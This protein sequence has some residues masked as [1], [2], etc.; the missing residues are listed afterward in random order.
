MNEASKTNNLRG[1]D[2]S[3][4]YLK[5]TVLDI[6]AGGDTVCEWARSFDV[7]DGD[8]NRITEYIA[9][10]SYDV[11]HSSHCLEHMFDPIDALNNWWSVLK[12]G[13]YLILVVPEENLYEQGLFP[14]FINDDHKST[15]RL[16]GEK[17]W[18]PLSYE[19]TKLCSD[20]PNAVILSAEIQ[21]AAYDR[22][23]IFPSNLKPNKKMPKRYKWTLSLLKRAPFFG[24]ALEQWY[25]KKLVF[26][27]F[28]FDQTRFS[29]LAQIE[30]IVRKVVS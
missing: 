21:D 13:G 27:G 20:L 2:F 1:P 22:R 24:A 30:I 17:S 23:F 6:G 3:E 29:A 16:G 5:G 7:E 15:F 28:P 18:S 10:E 4:K 25:R 26:R 9:P 19:V 8:A 12:N 14:L 11:V